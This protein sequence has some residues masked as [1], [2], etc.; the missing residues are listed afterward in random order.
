MPEEKKNAFKR[1]FRIYFV[2]N[3]PAYIVDEEGNEYVFHRTTHSKTSGGKKNWEKEHPLKN[4]DERKMH[5][6]R[7]EQRDNKARFSIFELEIKTGMDVSY[8]EI[9]KASD[10]SASNTGNHQSKHGY[11]IGRSRYESSTGST[12]ANKH[13]TIA[14]TGKHIKSNNRRKHNKRKRKK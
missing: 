10:I 1:H 12:K 8:P 9:K 7:K 5:I 14:Q 6:V 3:H 2:N 4:P 11:F 13:H